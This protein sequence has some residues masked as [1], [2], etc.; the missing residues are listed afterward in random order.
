MNKKDILSYY[1]NWAGNSQ[2]NEHAISFTNM[3]LKKAT[4]ALRNNDKVLAFGQLRT[5]KELETM[6]C[7]AEDLF[8]EK[9]E[10]RGV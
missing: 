10:L 4:F 7:L 3:L 5:G 6:Y 2:D 9:P 1:R 8:C